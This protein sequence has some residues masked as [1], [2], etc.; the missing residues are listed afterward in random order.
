MK[1]FARVL[2]LLMAVIC[3]GGCA[4]PQG[5]DDFP[6]ATPRPLDVPAGSYDTDNLTAFAWAALDAL[7]EGGDN[8]VF[9]P[10]ELAMLLCALQC[11]RADGMDEAIVAALGAQEISPRRI[12]EFAL[13][14]RQLMLQKNAGIAAFSMRGVAGENQA[15]Y[16]SY[17]QQLLGEL[18]L[19]MTFAATE[20]S[21]A[22]ETYA[23]W[24]DD[25]S[26]GMV[27]EVTWELPV[28]E[29]P[30]FVAVQYLHNYFQN[31]QDPARTVM[32]PFHTQDG[33]SAAAAFV[34]V[35][36]HCGIYRGD[37]G[38]MGIIPLSEDG[39]RLVVMM[40]GE[41]GTL[42]DL[43]SNAAQYH[44]AW[45]KEADWGE[46]RVA[47]PKFTARYDG[48]LKETLID[49]GL[50]AAFGQG[51]GMGLPR[52]GQGMFLADAM[53]SAT[54]VLDES[55]TGDVLPG[56]PF[57]SGM[58]D[59]IE[60]LLVDQPFLFAIEDTRTGL[61]IMAGVVRNPLAALR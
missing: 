44:T 36:Q 48:S 47:L 29:M 12:N 61:V 10:V 38:S 56:K 27:Q 17:I 41:E 55:G 35:V 59:G 15:V 42:E 21:S 58:D 57:R 46:Q 19:D 53:L 33:N 52:M 2:C 1:I 39:C 25:M 22:N 23:T 51:E 32:I 11:G 45:R 60:T 14:R 16:E 20:L 13:Q 9:S 34:P 3:L 6:V 24:A 49:M 7:Q 30:Y 54:F 50:G 26:N 43:M 40:P 28:D 8:T 4:K 5:E 31:A 18:E 37:E